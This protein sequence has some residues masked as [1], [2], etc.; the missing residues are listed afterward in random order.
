MAFAKIGLTEA[1][2]AG[3][4]D[5]CKAAGS[6]CHKKFFTTCGLRGKP[7]AALSEAFGVFDQDAS[8]YIEEEELKLFLQ[9]FSPGARELTPAETTTFLNAGDS[10][11]DGKIGVEEFIGLIKG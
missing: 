8:G 10:D 11:G 1:A 3:A 9:T 4:L 7:D 2:I 6:F 5:E